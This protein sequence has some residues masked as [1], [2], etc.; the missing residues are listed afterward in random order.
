MQL[1]ARR[2]KNKMGLK[3]GLNSQTLWEIQAGFPGGRYR[4]GV[5]G[6]ERARDLDERR[7]RKLQ[8]QFR[9]R[10]ASSAKRQASS[11]EP[12]SNDLKKSAD[13]DLGANG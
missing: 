6:E 9:S 8:R 5:R 3:I 4:I 7:A 12:L 2:G 13:F 10:R 11:A 1:L